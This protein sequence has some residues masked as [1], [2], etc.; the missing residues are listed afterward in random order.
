MSEH[1]D[2]NADVHNDCT[3]CPQGEGKK[4]DLIGTGIHE[5]IE[6]HL[7]VGHG[8]SDDKIEGLRLGGM[9]SGKGDLE[10]LNLAHEGILLFAPRTP[11]A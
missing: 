11:D 2:Y 3:P 4:C 5:G 6:R 8:W 1:R 10:V 7:G 9:L